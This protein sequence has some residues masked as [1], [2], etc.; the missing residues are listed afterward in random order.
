MS[1]GAMLTPVIEQFAA[2]IF[3]NRVNSIALHR[4]V[5]RYLC[6]AKAPDTFNAQHG[7][8]YLA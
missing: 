6:D 5:P 3:P 1:S 7:A 8:R 4:I 2:D